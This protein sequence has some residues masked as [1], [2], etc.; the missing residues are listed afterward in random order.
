MVPQVEWDQ[1]S[2]YVLVR[3]KILDNKNM[4]INLSE[5]NLSLQG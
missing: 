4:N 5:S 3:T 1:N 2:D